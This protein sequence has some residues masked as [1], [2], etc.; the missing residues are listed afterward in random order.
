M[1]PNSMTMSAK[2]SQSQGFPIEGS[3]VAAAATLGDTASMT[4]PERSGVLEL[5]DAIF[6][7]LL[8][9]RAD[10]LTDDDVTIVFVL[11]AV[12]GAAGACVTGVAE[13]VV[14]L[15]AVVSAF[16]PFDE[17]VPVISDARAEV[18]VHKNR[19]AAIKLMYKTD[20]LACVII[21]R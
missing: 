13:R 12:T 14:V 16:C 17:S 1:N 8:A 10:A 5:V 6:T 20:L 18:N 21:G 2:S 19:A 4:V 3:V 7:E 9:E 11:A 15:T